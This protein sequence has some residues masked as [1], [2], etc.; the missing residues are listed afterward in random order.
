MVSKNKLPHKSAMAPSYA[1]ASKV[2]TVY[3]EMIKPLKLR[4]LYK[5]MARLCSYTTDNVENY[6]KHYNEHENQLGQRSASEK[7]K[8]R[9]PAVKMS[10]WQQCAYCCV[11]HI[12]LSDLLEHIQTEHG[13]CLYQCAYCFYRAVSKSYIV[14]HQVN[15][16]YK[17]ALLPVRLGGSNCVLCK[18][19]SDISL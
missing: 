12:S 6:T 19:L 18:V 16:V 1:K 14:L 17:F 15:T 9:P 2:P 11:M 8:G 3:Q 4:H 5:C 10:D 7:K 13:H